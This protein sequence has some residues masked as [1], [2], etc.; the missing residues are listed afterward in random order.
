MT[1]TLC[2]ID[3]V[4]WETFI[5]QPNLITELDELL[6]SSFSDC[7]KHLFTDFLTGEYDD[8]PDVTAIFYRDRKIAG[9]GTLFIKG[10]QIIL[11]NLC[12]KSPRSGDFAYFLRTLIQTIVYGENSISTLMAVMNKRKK[13]Q[14]NYYI[15]SYVDI[16]ARNC[17]HLRGINTMCNINDVYVCNYF[18]KE[19]GY[20]K[21]NFPYLDMKWEPE[22]YDYAFVV[23]VKEGEI[24]PR[25]EKHIDNEIYSRMLFTNPNGTARKSPNKILTSSPTDSSSSSSNRKPGQGG[26]RK[27]VNSKYSVPPKRSQSPNRTTTPQNSPMVVTRSTP[28]STRSVQSNL[29]RTPDG[30][31]SSPDKRPETPTSS[32]SSARKKHRR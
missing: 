14:D 13:N 29:N 32:S 27:M 16:E 9:M 26:R 8:K 28:Q 3:F 12:V 22:Y 6:K 24:V 18:E 25:L 23:R 11:E 5:D 10:N 17:E 7:P 4:S 31:F 1:P 20:D 15:V 30:R 19:K 2:E 21:R